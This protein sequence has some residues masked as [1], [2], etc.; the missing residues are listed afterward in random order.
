MHRKPVP[1][2]QPT[3]GAAWPMDSFEKPPFPPP[4][5]SDEQM[6]ILE[7]ESASLHPD[8]PLG[9]LAQQWTNDLCMWFK[10]LQKHFHFDPGDLASN[11]RRSAPRWRRRMQYLKHTDPQRFEEVMDL[12]ENGHA[13]P[14]AEGVTPPRFFRRRNPPSLRADKVRAW[15]A[16]LKDI[17]HGAIAPVNIELEGMPWCVCPVRTADK[18]NGKARFVHN[19]RKVN[20]CIPREAV[21]CELETLLRIRNMFIPN[22]YVIG[23]DFAS[24]YHCLY[25]RESDRTYLAFA[26]HI[27]ELTQDA[28]DWLRKH[29]P[30]AYVHEKRCFVFK[31]IALPFGLSSS[32]RVFSLVVTALAGF[33]RTLPTEGESTRVSTYVDDANSVNETF[34]AALRMAIRIVYESASLGL[35]LQIPKCSFFPRH[36]IKT[37]G[38]IVDLSTFTF[39]VSR[40]RVA[41]I[42]SA[43]CELR[44]ATA[45][46]PRGVPARLVASFIGLIWSIAT[47]CH[48]AASVMLRSI[49][50]LLAAKMKSM[51][52]WL[53]APISIIL[54]R[55]WSGTVVWSSEAQAQLNFWRGVDFGALRAPISAD[56]LGQAIESTF[57]HPAML[58]HSEVSVLYQDA[59]AVAAGGGMLEMSRGRL[60]EA[61]GLFLAEFTAEQAI[62]SSTFRE[63]VG[64]LWCLQS[65][66]HITNQRIV[67]ACD[68]WQSVNAIRKGSRQPRIQEIAEEIF[69]WCLANNR[70]VWPVWLPRTDPIIREADRRSRMLI[71]HDARTPQPVVDAANDM[72]LETWHLHLSF[73]QAASH[74]SAIRVDGHR[75]PFNAYCM[76][77]GASGVDTF[78]CWQSWRANV[79][80][81]NPPAPMTGRLVTFLPTTGARVVLVIPTPRDQAWWHYAIMPSAEGF[82]A[83]LKFMGFTITVFDFSLSD[84]CKEPA[85]TGL[86]T[87]ACSY[88]A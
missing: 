12:I 61:A 3:P 86:T 77:P 50:A 17:S 52:K 30:Y 88:C 19:S 48:R 78:R 79:N 24:G 43:I 55:F 1:V 31:Y 74:R 76:Q 84:I 64:I 26:L 62:A 81:I 7:A 58:D 54:S 4:W 41:K 80:F 49:V 39:Q 47:C 14:F 56:V 57:H 18:S 42:R 8:A 13:I 59:S 35:S 71:P 36:S 34:K 23:S 73:D 21:Q 85:P 28:L 6:A 60:R 40:S 70:M 68:N 45:T 82:S 87:T 38:T 65:T 2:L 53:N 5:P 29:H 63:L 51:I 27:S 72:A 66:A 37:L 67:F 10:K 20:K 33:W 83:Q 15:E 46:N 9:P 75:L 11:V 22:G 44:Q 32:C 16:I 69:R 25:I